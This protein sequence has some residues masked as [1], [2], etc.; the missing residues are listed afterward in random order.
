MTNIPIYRGKRI[1]IHGY[2]VIDKSFNKY[3]I[4]T[5]STLIYNK[6]AEDYLRTI[7]NIE[8]AP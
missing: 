7:F 2:L 4:T 8:I 5:D 6:S 3:F 1:D